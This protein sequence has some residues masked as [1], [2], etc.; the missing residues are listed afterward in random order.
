MVDSVGAVGARAQSVFLSADE[1]VNERAG[2]SVAKAEETASKPSLRVTDGAQNAAA[3]VVAKANPRAVRQADRLVP[4]A[5]TQTVDDLIAAQ[6]GQVK[7]E[8]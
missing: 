5:A 2:G 1:T 7:V 8:G 4:T 6:G 3:A